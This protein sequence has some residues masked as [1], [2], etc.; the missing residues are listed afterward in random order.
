V[1]WPAR[2]TRRWRRKQRLAAP[3]RYY[4]DGGT[5]HHS[6]ILDV[7]TADG[8]VVAVWFRCQALPFREIRVEPARAAEMI[9][10]PATARITGVEL[11]DPITPPPA[12]S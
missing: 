5:W 6:Q 9:A 3:G 7:E 12:R 1:N 10:H 4:G 2:I 11:I 8:A